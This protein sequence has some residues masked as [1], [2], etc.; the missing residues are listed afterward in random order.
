M[1]GRLTRSLISAPL[2][3]TTGHVARPLTRAPLPSAQCDALPR[4]PVAQK[5]SFALGAAYTPIK[6]RQRQREGAAH[7]RPCGKVGHGNRGGALERGDG[8]HKPREDLQVSRQVAAP[9]HQ[10]ARPFMLRFSGCSTAPSRGA[11][12]HAQVGRLRHRAIKRRAHSCSDRN[13]PQV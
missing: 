3:L 5:G 10:G 7:L 4:G 13:R 8:V 12:T 6:R 11:P 9:C 1:H 2:H